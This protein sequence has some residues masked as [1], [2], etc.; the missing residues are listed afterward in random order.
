MGSFSAHLIYSLSA[1]WHIYKALMLCFHLSLSL[2]AVVALL[3]PSFSIPVVTV[4]ALYISS[5]LFWSAY[6]YPSFFG[7]CYCRATYPGVLYPFNMTNP[8]PFPT[9]NYIALSCCILF[10]NWR[11]LF[12][13]LYDNLTLKRFFP[14]NYFEMRLSSFCL[15]LLFTKSR[16]HTRE[17]KEPA[18]W[19]IQISYDWKVLQNSNSSEPSNYFKR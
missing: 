2:A 14:G 10:F 18:C 4:P 19:I 9:C 7:P 8:V 12:D 1:S 17:L 11:F 3:M 15:V 6:F 16:F 13:I 5:M